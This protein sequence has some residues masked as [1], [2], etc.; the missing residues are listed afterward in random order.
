LSALIC[1]S[2]ARNT[3][4]RFAKSWA[5]KRTAGDGLSPAVIR[6]INFI[7]ARPGSAVTGPV[8]V[9]GN[10]I[11]SSDH[12]LSQCIFAVHPIYATV[13][14]ISPSTLRAGA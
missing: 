8:H 3:F 13:R 6:G 10:F 9:A 7:L 4:P 1:A 14:R 2:Q 5:Q 12:A 11:I